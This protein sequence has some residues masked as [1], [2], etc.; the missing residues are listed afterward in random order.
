MKMA[1]EESKREKRNWILSV[2]SNICIIL[3][4]VGLLY[5]EG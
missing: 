1:Y 4:G 5:F 2:I 3:L